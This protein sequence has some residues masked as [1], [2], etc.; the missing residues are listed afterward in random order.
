MIRDFISNDYFV[1]VLI[2]WPFL[3]YI[4][5]KKNIILKLMSADSTIEWQKMATRLNVACHNVGDFSDSRSRSVIFVWKKTYFVSFFSRFFLNSLTLY[6]ITDIKKMTLRV[7]TFFFRH[8]IRTKMTQR[9][10]NI[11]LFLKTD[12]KSE[13]KWRYVDR[14]YVVLRTDIKS[15]KKDTT[16]VNLSNRQKFKKRK[17]RRANIK[18]FLKDRRKVRKNRH[19]VGPT[20][21]H[22]WK[23]DVKSEHI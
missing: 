22:F 23:T 8:N 13:Q 11:K 2:I 17:Q 21:S 9:K 3:S 20:L 5:L 1:N 6:F 15:E 10:P 16:S 19:N 4:V 18:S 14:H 7:V 12:L